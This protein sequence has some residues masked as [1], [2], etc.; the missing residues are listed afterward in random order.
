VTDV[1][2]AVDQIVVADGFAAALVCDVLGAKCQSKGVTCFVV[3]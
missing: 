1:F 2:A 3:A